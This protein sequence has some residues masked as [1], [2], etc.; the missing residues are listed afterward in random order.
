MLAYLW[1]FLC[2]CFLLITSQK[3]INKEIHILATVFDE[4][5][6]WYLDDNINTFTKQPKSVK[7]DDEDFQLS[8]KMNCKF[9]KKV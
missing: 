5:L 4:N 9:F 1:T 7:K 3:N 8:N 2:N 6:S